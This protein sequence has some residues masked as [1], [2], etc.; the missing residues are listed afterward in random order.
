MKK[1]LLILIGIVVGCIAWAQNT[2]PLPGQSLANEK[3]Q[4]DTLKTSYI[5]AG[6]KTPNCT[7]FSV[8]NTRILKQPSNG[9]WKEEW[10]INACGKQVFVPI[11][12]ILDPTG[13]TF[14]ISQ[15]EIHL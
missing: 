3:L 11:T 2:L 13:A 4:A 8:A 7:N 14:S 5:A 9:Y 1:L 10:Q 15:N 6:T 12:F